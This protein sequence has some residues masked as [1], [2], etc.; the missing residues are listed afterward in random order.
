MNA[1][2]GRVAHRNQAFSQAAFEKL[3]AF[4]FWQQLFAFLIDDEIEPDQQSLPAHIRDRAMVGRERP[5][6]VLQG[7]SNFGRILG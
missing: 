3:D 6:S 7:L 5:Q 1:H 2:S 4:F